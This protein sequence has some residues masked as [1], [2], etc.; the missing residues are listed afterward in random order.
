MA[1]E[2]SDRYPPPRSQ[3]PRLLE[4]Y[5]A[6]C[7]GCG[8]DFTDKPNDLEVDHIRPKSDGGTDAYENLTLLCPPCNRSKSDTMTLTGLQQRNRREGILRPEN[9]INLK[10]GRGA[11]N[12]WRAAFTAVQELLAAEASDEWAAYKMAEAQLA[13]T[14][15]DEWMGLV[16]SD[17][18]D[19]RS[20]DAR[21]EREKAKLKMAAPP[22]EW[23]ALEEYESKMAK[24]KTA[25]LK[26]EAQLARTYP[27]EW[28]AYK[29][30]DSSEV[31]QVATLHGA[32]WVVKGGATHE[33]AYQK[34]HAL[35]AEAKAA[36]KAAMGAAAPEEWAAAH[37]EW[38]AYE[39]AYKEYEAMYDDAWVCPE[40]W[41]GK[42]AS[43]A[44]LGSEQRSALYGTP[45]GS[46]RKAAMEE[47]MAAHK[48]E[49][50]RHIEEYE[51]M[52]PDE[53]MDVKMCYLWGEFGSP[54]Y[55]AEK[56]LRQAAPDKWA[57]YEKAK[58]AVDIRMVWAANISD[59]YKGWT[60]AM[61]ALAAAAPDAADVYF[62]LR[63]A[64]R[65]AQ[66]R[67]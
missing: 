37:D 45:E 49:Y 36:L 11:N 55:D 33:E 42:M 26:A 44:L 38:K 66:A 29:A 34:Y 54:V 41:A 28:T 46:E 3:H 62:A 57:A 43:D 53:W 60:A 20:A 56:A 18:T 4:K 12:K 16:V 19:K 23:A 22:D 24:L 59:V 8:C 30:Y 2:N 32:L 27:D 6:Y 61:N 17:W 14:Y 65:D 64:Y 63:S 47:Y 21:L 39:S 51:A 5:G 1:R 35:K 25:K 67:K 40:I 52:T 50:E 7:Q 58:K 10:L 15:P 9:E 13:R 48:A 31:R